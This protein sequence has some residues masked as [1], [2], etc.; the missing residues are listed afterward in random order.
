[1]S[2]PL[3]VEFD[4]IARAVITEVM[5][6]RATVSGV[7]YDT[8]PVDIPVRALWDTGAGMSVISA[9]IVEKLTLSSAGNG[10]LTGIG[11]AVRTELYDISVTLP[12][13]ALFP[14]IRAAEWEGS[15]NYDMLIGMDIISRGKFTIDN[16]AGK[17]IFTF[18][19]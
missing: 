1:M 14:L 16:G 3:K 18:N 19:V 10:T 11:G 7:V 17:T 5:I 12:N 9:N 2:P 8:A 4:Y 6:R 15:R 13:K